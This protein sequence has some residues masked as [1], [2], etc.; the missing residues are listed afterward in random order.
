MSLAYIGTAGSGEVAA[1]VSSFSIRVSRLYKRNKWPAWLK[2]TPNLRS[3]QWSDFCK[4]EWVRARFIA[5]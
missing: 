2:I 5:G 4:Q 1:L 3:A